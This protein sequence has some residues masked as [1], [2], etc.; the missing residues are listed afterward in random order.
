MKFNQ[1][2]VGLAA[3]GVV[4]LASAV[5]A[6]EAKSAVQTML[7][8]TTISGYVDTAAI[9][10]FG[11]GNGYI[12]GRSFDQG[13]PAASINKQDGFNLNV[14]KLTIEKPL[15]EGQWAAGYKV[16]LLY[17]PDANVFNTASFGATAQDFAVKNAYIQLRAPVGNGLDLKVGVWDT[18][19]GY[20]VFEA[21]NNPNY[22]RSYGYFLEPFVHTGVLASYR[23]ADFLTASAGIADSARGGSTLPGTSSGNTIN[24]RSAVESRKDFMGSVALTAPE[25]FGA[26]KGSTLYAG[27]IDGNTDGAKDRLNL[28]VGATVNTGVKGLSVGAAY[29]YVANGIFNSSYANAVSLYGSFQASE[30]LKLNLRGE[31]ASASAGTFTGTFGSTKSAANNERFIGVTA[32]VDYAL[33]ANVISRVEFRWDHDAAGGNKVINTGNSDGTGSFKNVASLALNLIYKF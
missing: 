28:Y 24:G 22:S 8:H 16:D 33:W 18:I 1:W 26:L 21:G 19:I 12:P 25:S 5:N 23:L 13:S 14:V 27:V 6:E 7:S 15:D 32:T 9:W 20:E 11:T 29:D 17:G 2:T 30:K 10:R 4:S 31:Y 3:A